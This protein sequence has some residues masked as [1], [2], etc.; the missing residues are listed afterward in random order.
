MTD[1]T[2]DQNRT[3]LG[4]I[5][6]TVNEANKIIAGKN[7]DNKSTSSS[8][9][10]KENDDIK[11]SNSGKSKIG[12][13]VPPLANTI[14]SKLRPP[15]HTST[16][17]S[18]SNLE[19]KYV[20]VQSS[21]YGKIR[22]SSVPRSISSSNDEETK[23]LLYGAVKALSSSHNRTRPSSAPRHRRINSA[24]GSPSKTQK[25]SNS[26]I[27][28]N[29]VTRAQNKRN[30]GTTA[31][32]LWRQE[33][34]ALQQKR[35]EQ[36]NQLNSNNRATAKTHKRTQSDRPFSYVDA[37]ESPRKA[38]KT[39][40][41]DTPQSPKGTNNSDDSTSNMN[42]ANKALKSG[43][44][45]NTPIASIKNVL[46]N[47]TP[48]KLLKNKTANTP[49]A[50]IESP[51]RSW[52]KSVEISS[53]ASDYFDRKKFALATDLATFGSPSVQTTD[54][55]TLVDE[56]FAPGT[57]LTDEE[58]RKVLN[59]KVP[60]TKQWDLKKKVDLS[61]SLIKKLRDALNSYLQA[62]NRLVSSAIEK[63]RKAK[64]TRNRVIHK[65]QLYEEENAVFKSK[66]KNLESKHDELNEKYKDTDRELLQTQEKLVGMGKELDSLR[67]KMAESEVTRTQ[68]EI[69]LAVLEGR[70]KEAS[71]QADR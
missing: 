44:A 60:A 71:K 16:K 18:M 2:S 50:P 56:I 41:V 12:L 66:L 7:S 20:D 46:Q 54:I 4:I 67:A 28:S 38:M 45:A 43:S 3:V 6:N 9:S 11:A 1:G 58:M 29:S 27:R 21:G 37:V 70:C 19:K 23:S 40:K 36:H 49:T 42:A 65:A 51:A 69:N 5:C 15:K 47:M 61:N 22:S 68:A 17:P 33:Q 52:S 64:S 32:S 39:S 14:N 25:R 26:R 53:I 30:G 13:R 31:G 35:K 48:T 8:D 63:E 34:R 62:K 59:T 10:S 55:Q 24:P 57:G